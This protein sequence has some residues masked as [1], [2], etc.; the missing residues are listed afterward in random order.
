[1]PC[2]FSY[3]TSL[4]DPLLKGSASCV[5]AEFDLEPFAREIGAL[6]KFEKLVD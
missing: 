6:K 2:A 5:R 1:M 3:C 4:V